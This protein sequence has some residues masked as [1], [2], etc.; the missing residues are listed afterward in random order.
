[1]R[2]QSEVKYS[3]SPAQQRGIA[4]VRFY[5]AVVVHDGEMNSADNRE[6]RT[7][8]EVASRRFVQPRAAVR[9]ERNACEK[10]GASADS[11]SHKQKT[12]LHSRF[13]RARAR[14]ES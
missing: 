9:K 11:A 1:V 12:A 8:Q 13:I 5:R 7:S 2:A 4:R 3:F 10:R 14:G 6:I